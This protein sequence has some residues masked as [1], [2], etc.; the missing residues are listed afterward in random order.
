VFRDSYSADHSP[1]PNADRLVG[2]QFDASDRS[3]RAT[4]G[5]EQF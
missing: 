5:S 2:R 1:L 3:G 4:S